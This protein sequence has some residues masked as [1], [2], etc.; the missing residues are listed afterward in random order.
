[1]ITIVTSSAAYLVLVAAA[2]TAEP[3]LGAAIGAAA[4]AA[5]GLTIL[6]GARVRSPGELGGLHRRL[7]AWEPPV[8]RAAEVAMLMLAIAA[9]AI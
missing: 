3:A 6:A 9:A 4:G 1:V 7:R 5:R 2:L 8:R